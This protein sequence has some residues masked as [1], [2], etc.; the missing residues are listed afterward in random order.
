[1]FVGVWP[2]II[3]SHPMW[4]WPAV[5]GL[6]GVCGVF[7]IASATGPWTNGWPGLLWVF[8]APAAFCTGAGLFGMMGSVSRPELLSDAAVRAL[9][10]AVGLCGVMCAG[11]IVHTPDPGTLVAAYAPIVGPLVFGAV[12][13]IACTGAAIVARRTDSPPVSTLQI[14]RKKREMASSIQRSLGSF[15][16]GGFASL[17]EDRA[18]W[19]PPSAVIPLLIFLAAFA[20]I[21][22]HDQRSFVMLL[23]LVSLI[24][25]SLFRHSLVLWTTIQIGAA[26]LGGWLLVGDIVGCLSAAAICALVTFPLARYRQLEPT[27]AVTISLMALVLP[28]AW[29]NLRPNNDRRCVTA[30]VYSLTFTVVGALG[31]ITEH[32][33]I[34]CRDFTPLG[35][36]VDLATVVVLDEYTTI[37]NIISALWRLPVLIV[38]LEGLLFNCLNAVV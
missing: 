18:S 13:A 16:S 7:M 25:R 6:I 2:L 21:P 4:R 3:E 29:C 35:G 11:F 38:V 24:T 28:V 22:V 19:L 15:V 10:L 32:R 5:A 26:A 31:Y 33:F 27:W 14:E 20:A 12:I 23:P 30:A 36:Q 34:W 9:A 37:D 1:M 17:K 8:T